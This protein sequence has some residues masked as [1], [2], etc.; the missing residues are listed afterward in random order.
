MR[1][2]KPSI[3]AGW[4]TVSMSWLRAW[5]WCLNISRAHPMTLILIV[6][7]YLCEIMQ[8]QV[9]HDQWTC[10]SMTWNEVECTSSA[11]CYH[12]HRLFTAQNCWGLSLSP[13]PTHIQHPFDHFKADK[14]SHCVL[15]HLFFSILFCQCGYCS[16]MMFY[17]VATCC[18]SR[19]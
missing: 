1:P 2:P 13:G 4:E 6:P 16:S 18:H 9:K 5:L 7:W 10:S 19:T 15:C 17:V 12:V 8:I 3:Q 14:L 11:R